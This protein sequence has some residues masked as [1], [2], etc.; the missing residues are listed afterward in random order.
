MCRALLSWP[1]YAVMAMVPCAVR[2]PAFIMRNLLEDGEGRKDFV[3]PLTQHLSRRPPMPPLV[4]AGVERY[5][6]HVEGRLW[7]TKEARGY[8][9]STTVDPKSTGAEATSSKL[10]VRGYHWFWDAWVD[11]PVSQLQLSLHRLALRAHPH[12]PQAECPGVRSRTLAVST[13]AAVKKHGPTQEGRPARRRS[14]RAT[15]FHRGVGEDICGQSVHGSHSLRLVVRCDL[16]T[17]GVII[18]YM[19]VEPGV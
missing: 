10:Q 5:D 11:R 4:R 7:E 9:L 15:T 13:V 1:G 16:G 14:N 2:C 17:S 18:S 6:E 19:L 3:R 12:P 8:G